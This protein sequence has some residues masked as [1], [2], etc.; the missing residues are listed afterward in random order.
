MRL[1][2]SATLHA[3]HE[4]GAG[5]PRVLMLDWLQE[6]MLAGVLQRAI[7]E[8]VADGEV[9]TYDL[10]GESGTLDVARAVADRL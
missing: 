3:F 7:S 6:T 2:T 8:V 1:G 10:G 5:S 4:K 9:R